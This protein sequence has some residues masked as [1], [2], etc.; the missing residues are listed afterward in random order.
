M[1]HADEK[2]IEVLN[3]PQ[4]LQ[5][6]TMR[7][8]SAEISYYDL[9]QGFIVSGALKFNKTTDKTDILLASFRK[10]MKSQNLTIDKLYKHYDPQEIRFVFRNEFIDTSKLIG[11]E[12][13]DD[14]F[15]QIFTAF[16]S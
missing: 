7:P 4:K 15:N 14:Q 11:F 16:A 5:K 12:F 1:L 13:D 6:D 2:K 3:G 9:I 10:Q 8:K